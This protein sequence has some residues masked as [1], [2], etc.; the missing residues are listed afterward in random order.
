ML[1]SLQRF[2]QRRQAPADPESALMSQWARERG[3]EF[4]RVRRGPGAV[5]QSVGAAGPMRIEWGP[6][7]RQYIRGSELRVRIDAKLPDALE[8][9]VLSRSL[10]ESLEAQ[11]FQELTSLQQTGMDEGSPEEAR[12][13]ALFERIDVAAGPTFEQ[14]FVVV[15]SCVPHARH[16][17]AGELA[18]RLLRARTHWLS[19]QAP[20]V[21]MTL[22]GRLYLRTEAGVLD[23]T[24]LDGVRILA[25]AAAVRAR[26]ISTRAGRGSSA[27]PVAAGGDL[28]PAAIPPPPAGPAG[29]AAAAVPAVAASAIPGLATFESD[30]PLEGFEL[31]GL[32]D[33]DLPGELPP[34]GVPIDTDLTL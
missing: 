4:K 25:D 20:L 9:L 18:V 23:E 26:K 29:V 27:A 24:L 34:L 17:A 15:S 2:L 10:A 7:Q 32:H 21:L 12:W 1:D 6:P 5:V 3:D 28:A 16:W 22:R 13:L 14:G 11:A 33:A 8:M 19:A 30:D 31:D